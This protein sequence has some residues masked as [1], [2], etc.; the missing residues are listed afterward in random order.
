MIMCTFGIAFL[1]FAKSSNRV[2]FVEF[3]NNN[4]PCWLHRSTALGGA[5]VVA[6]VV[7]QNHVHSVVELFHSSAA[8]SS[9]VGPP[10][11]TSFVADYMHCLEWCVVLCVTCVRM[12]VDVQHRYSSGVKHSALC[13]GVQ[14]PLSAAGSRQDVLES[15]TGLSSNCVTQNVQSRQ[16]QCISSYIHTYSTTVGLEQRSNNLHK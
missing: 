9:N 10:V 5:G 7:L 1:Q 11:G 4:V 16:H 12:G 15:C 14:H 3:W 6:N 13:H 2:C 8:D